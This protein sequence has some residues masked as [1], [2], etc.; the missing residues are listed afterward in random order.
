LTTHTSNN[1]T[2]GFFAQKWHD[3][4]VRFGILYTEHPI[5][6]CICLALIL[7]LILEILNH[8]SFFRGCW[9]VIS[10]TFVFCYNAAIILVFLALATLFRR[11]SF[12][13]TLVSAI[14]LIL[15]ITNCILN[16]IRSTPF[17]ATDVFNLASV[18]PVIPKY[19]KFW[20]IILICVFLILL[21]FSMAILFRKSRKFSVHY[22]VAICFFCISAAAVAAVTSVA[23]LVSGNVS[24]SFSD[25]REAYEKC[26]FVFCFSSS[27]VDRGIEE[28]D[29][30]SSETVAELIENLEINDSTS[31]DFRPNIIMLQLESFFDV[32]NIYDVAYSENPVP[33][34]QT[35]K[36]Q[37]PSGYLTVPSVGAGT[38]NTEFEAISGMSLGFFGIGEY[39]YR[40]VLQSNTCETVCYNLKELG[41]STHAIHN[42]TGTF[43][44]RYKVFS[45]LGFD[46]FT[47]LE[48]MKN[49]LYTPT[50]WAKDAIL[51]DEIT[52]ALDSTSSRDFIYTI[53]VQ[54]HGSYPDEEVD[55]NTIKVTETGDEKTYKFENAGF[56]YYVNQAKEVDSFLGTLTE[57]LSEWDEPVIL[58]MYG[59]HLPTFYLEEDELVN[60]DLYQTEYVIWSNFTLDAE[61]CDLYSYQLSSYVMGLAGFENGALTKLHQTEAGSREYMDDLKIL[62]YDMLYGDWNIY[63]GVNPYQPTNLQMGT[64]PI[65]IY[66][67]EIIDDH[68]Y[69][70]GSG[71]TQWS[72]ASINRETVDT[73]YINSNTL[74]IHLPDTISRT[75]NIYVDQVT[76]EGIS[77]SRTETYTL[78]RD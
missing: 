3:I 73:I 76:D 4:S 58:V 41:Y 42:N 27:L 77:L 63:D 52:K 26:G 53:S 28:P 19:L 68:I 49:P 57:T 18:L 12:A 43:Y 2:S 31:T 48:Y 11:R 23:Y 75:L 69:I 55:G 8:C 10:N 9:A 54:C 16:T 24:R 38:A 29:E 72:Q 64:V 32:N 67:A 47:S 71:F 37:Y 74:Q 56:E 66:S 34:F 13:L 20:Q 33:V 61:D 60:G 62:E 7:N 70:T 50:G 17:T 46:T 1:K 59:D 21:I 65:K 39:P 15:G 22:K 36:K 35:L 30:Y 6:F 25:I 14:W 44:D 51:T 5:R 40:T 78:L 45:N